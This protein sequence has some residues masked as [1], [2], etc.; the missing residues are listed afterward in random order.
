MQEK[1]LDQV[2]QA[3]PECERQY[4]EPKDPEDTEDWEDDLLEPL[5]IEDIDTDLA[6]SD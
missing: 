4:L 2:Y 1:W 3:W 6:D 5:I